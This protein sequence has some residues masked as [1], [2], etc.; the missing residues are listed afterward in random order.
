MKAVG[1]MLGVMPLKVLI[2]AVGGVTLILTF[3]LKGEGI[4]GDGRLANRPYRVGGRRGWIPACAG[5]TEGW[6][7]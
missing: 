4:R 3:S 2:M 1:W 7:E 6:R 5:M